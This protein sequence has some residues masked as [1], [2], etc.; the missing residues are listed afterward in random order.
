MLVVALGALAVGSLIA[1]V[2]P[3][4]GVLIFARVVQGVGGGVLP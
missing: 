1:A 3:T 2:A 4:I